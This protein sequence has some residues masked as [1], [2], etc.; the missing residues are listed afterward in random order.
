MNQIFMNDPASFLGRVCIDNRA[1]MFRTDGLNA[2]DMA[3]LNNAKVGAFDFATGNP[4]VNIMLSTCAAI[5]RV[6]PSHQVVRDTAIDAYWCPFHAGS[7]DTIGWVDV[8]RRAPL[9]RFIFTAAMQGCCY[10]V[11]NS[12]AS[13]AH[14][15]VWHNQHPDM[16]QSWA[17]INASGATTVY[18]QLTYVDY[19]ANMVNAFNIL[20]RPPKGAWRYVSQSN[21]FVPS[22]PPTGLVARM[23]G[24]ARNYRPVITVR[25]AASKP[26]LT[27][28]A[29]V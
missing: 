20:W 5:R 27:L 10:V 26:I 18:S 14:F 16:A 19:G 25:R 9:Y 6:C 15:R 28:P 7:P 29:G 1:E 3:A 13:P 17:T 21:L 12:P 4:D 24:T 8:P 2:M 22:P 23:T 11:T